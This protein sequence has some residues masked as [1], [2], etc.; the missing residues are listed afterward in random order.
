MAKLQI[1]SLLKGQC[2]KTTGNIWIPKGFDSNKG[3]GNNV[4]IGCNCDCPVG[5]NEI[6]DSSKRCSSKLFELMSDNY[7]PKQRV[8]PEQVIQQVESGYIEHIDSL[9]A[10]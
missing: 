2:I 8:L 10:R 4:D 6:E 1:L 5:F 9:I 3:R 7:K